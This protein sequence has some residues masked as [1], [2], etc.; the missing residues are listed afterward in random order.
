VRPKVICG[1]GQ[2]GRNASDVSAA[3]QQSKHAICLV[4]V[5]GFG[6]FVYIG[7][8]QRVPPLCKNPSDF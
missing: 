6:Y 3:L 8:S 2:I 4:E 7:D 1:L 5:L